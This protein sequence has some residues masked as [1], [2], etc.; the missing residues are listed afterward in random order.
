[1]EN[2]LKEDKAAARS[3][4]AARR[5]RAHA[6][7]GAEAPARVVAH[8][9][10]AFD[11]APGAVVS[12]YWPI[13]SELDPRPLARRLLAAGHELC[14]P[15]V[16]A[17]GAPLRFRRWRPDTEMTKGNFGVLVPPEDAGTATPDVL[18]VPLLAYDGAGYRLGYGGGF[19]DRT[20]RDLRARGPR[21]AVGIAFS[22]QKVA[23]VPRG[24]GD[25]PL[26]AVVT[27]AGVERFGER[28][29]R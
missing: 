19:Y 6:A 21:L 7:A 9:E 11:P 23:R 10:A 5:D 3:A 2:T 18:L 1:M 24:P 15:V 28:P 17:R 8:F 4:A 26:D 16:E 12:F 29:G 20:L 27:E 13:L 25:E 22:A 14:L